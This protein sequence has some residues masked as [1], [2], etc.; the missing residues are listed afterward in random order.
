MLRYVM[1]GLLVH[2]YAIFAVVFCLDSVA[3]RLTQPRVTEDL[4]HAR[5]VLHFLLSPVVLLLYSLVEFVAL[6]EL[7]IRGRDVCE[8]KPSR[9]D[10]L[11]TSEGASNGAFVIDV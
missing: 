3:I 10:Q 9:K 11:G 2:Q 1:A 7:A 8:H 4:S 6:H 5:N